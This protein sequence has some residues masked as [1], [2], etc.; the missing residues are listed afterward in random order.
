MHGA[1]SRELALRELEGAA[2]FGL[3]VFLALDDARVAGQEALALDRAA[4]LGLLAGEAGGDSMADGAGLAGEA[5]ALDGGD[6]VILA[7]GVGD[8]EHLVDDQAKR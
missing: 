2:G 6:H 1:G 4:Q 8:V 5:A 7:A 3:A